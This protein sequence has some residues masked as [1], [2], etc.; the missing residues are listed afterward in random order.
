MALGSMEMALVKSATAEG[1]R[2]GTLPGYPPA[3]ARHDV[4]LDRPEN[5]PS[6]D[7]FGHNRKPRSKHENTG[8]H[9]DS[10]AAYDFRGGLH[11]QGS[12]KRSAGYARGE[13]NLPFVCLGGRRICFRWINFSG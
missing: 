7:V 11:G 1:A 6:S 3:A 9:F 10:G 5:A 13:L 4:S 2:A 8:R 12:D